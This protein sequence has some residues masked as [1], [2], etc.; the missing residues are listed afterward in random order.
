MVKNQAGAMIAR[1]DAAGIL[2]GA[3]LASRKSPVKGRVSRGMPRHVFRIGNMVHLVDWPRH[4]WAIFPQLV[5]IIP[6]PNGRPTGGARTDTV[7]VL[8]PTAQILA[9]P[10][11]TGNLLQRKN[12]WLTNTS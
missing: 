10:I 8:G 5:G 9:Q 1:A 4:T 12:L 6:G 3:N 11:G 2:T 7:Q